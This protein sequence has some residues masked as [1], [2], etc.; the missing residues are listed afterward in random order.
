V[1]ITIS[2]TDHVFLKW[3]IHPNKTI[4]KGSNRRYQISPV[5]CNPITPSDRPHRLRTDIFRILFALA[6]HTEWSLL[7]HD[8]IGDWMI[9]FAANALATAAAKIVNAFEWPEQPPKIA[10]SRGSA[11]RLIYGSLG[12]PQ[13]SSKTACRSVQPFLH[14]LP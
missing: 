3:Q 2:A 13:S 5:M 7:L 1:I 11:P 4:L 8:I 9:P 14:S 12:L 10:P 6:W